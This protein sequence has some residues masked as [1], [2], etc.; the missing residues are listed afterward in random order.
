VK[1][2]NPKGS[3]SYS[4]IASALTLAPGA[5]T[6]GGGG[7][8][9]VVVP[10]GTRTEL[11]AFNSRGYIYTID[12]AGNGSKFLLPIAQPSNTMDCKFSWNPDATRMAIRYIDDKGASY[13]Y[14]A[15]LDGTEGNY[16]NNNSPVIISAGSVIGDRPGAWSPDGKKFAFVSTD[17]GKDEI[18]TQNIDGTNLTRLT[19]FDSY[20]PDWSPDGTKIAYFWLDNN[21]ALAAIYTMDAG[22]GNIAKIADTCMYPVWSPDSSKIAFWSGKDNA[23]HV[24]N[25]DGTNEKNITGTNVLP[26][27]INPYSCW[28]PSSDK[29]TFLMNGDI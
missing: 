29:I 10:G 28:S 14:T 27:P 2:Y 19:D 1:A 7:G 4:N 25:G 6:I 16:L 20:T 13:L 18:F 5:S 12:P 15:N 3:S 24:I 21:N 11:I 23:L 17:Q 8:G 9:G 26:D 22:G